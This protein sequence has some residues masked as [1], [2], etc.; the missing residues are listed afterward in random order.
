METK[1]MKHLSK[2]A[3]AILF[4]LASASATPTLDCEKDFRPLNPN[5]QY[6]LLVG[7]NLQDAGCCEKNVNMPDSECAELK[8]RWVEKVCD[9]SVSNV[10]LYYFTWYPEGTSCVSA[11]CV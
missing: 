2:I 11:G 7:H 1:Q 6:E 5:C 9:D 3:I 8:K 10:W 4:A